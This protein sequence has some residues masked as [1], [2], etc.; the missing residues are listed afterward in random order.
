M[1]AKGNLIQAALVLQTIAFLVC[2]LSP[3]AW[4][5]GTAYLTGYVF[6]PTGATVPNATVV[7]KNEVTSALFNLRTTEAGLYRSPALTPGSYELTVTAS[8]FQTLVSRGVKVETGQPRGLN[9]TLQVGEMSQQV[10]VTASAPLLKTEDPGLGQSVQ[11]EAVKSLP[12]FN[13]SAGTLMQLSPGVRYTGEDALSYGSSRYNVGGTT[14][15]EVQVDGAGVMGDRQGAIQM[16][17]NPSVESLT[18]A[19]VTSNQY[20]SEHGWQEGAVIQM[21]TKSGSNLFHG[22]VYEY[23]RNE[24]MDTY[25]GFTNTKPLD[26]QHVF[27]G[28]LGG[29][30]KKNK[31]VF[32][33]SL[34]GWRL[35]TPSGTTLTVPTADMKRG[36]FSKLTSAAGAPTLIFDPKTTRVDPGTGN[37]VRDPFPG[38][39]IPS[40]R[41]DA[42]AANALRYIPDP[43]RS[44]LVQNLSG[45]SGF[46]N[47]KFKG[48][49]RIDWTITDKDKLFG[50]WMFDKTAQTDLGFSAY[51]AIDP[52]ASPGSASAALGYRYFTQVYNFNHVHI[53]SPTTFLESRFVYKPRTIRRVQAAINPEKHYAETLGIKNYAGARL[54]PELGGDLG[55]PTFN[56][57]GYTQ[58]GPGMLQFVEKPINQYS[59]HVN[60]SYLHGKHAT[61]FGFQTERGQHGAP[62]QTLPTG[63]FNFGPIQTSRPGAANT[64]N[65][66]ASFLLGQVN[67]GQ[68]QLGPLQV[69]Q[70]WYYAA[71]IQDD[72]KVTPKLTVNLG[73][74]WDIDAPLHERENKANAFDAQQINPVS[75][76][77]GVYRFFGLDGWPTNYFDTDYTRFAPR[78]GFAWQVEPKTVIRGGYGIYNINMVL[79]T[80]GAPREGYNTIAGFTS[81][82]GGLSP[83]F[84]LQDG[85]PDYPLGGDVSRL[86]A[87]FGAVRVG[88]SPTNSPSFVS[89]H[90]NFGYTQNFNLSVMRELPWNMVLEVAGQ[91]S[92]GRNL[93]MT[94]NWNEVRPEL[95][96]ISGSSFPRRPFPQFNN[97]T[98][99]KNQSGT[100]NFYAGYVRLEKRM[101]EGLTIISNYSYGKTLG[102]LSGS[103]YFPRFSRGPTV[104]DQGNGAT[105]APYHTA[106]VSWVYNLPFGPGKSHLSSGLASK[107]LG[108]WDVS[109]ILT[110]RGGVPFD[111]TSGADS[112]NG[113]SPLGG[114][115]NLIGNPESGSR[116]VSRWFNTDAFAR[117]VAGRV[118]DFCCGVLRSP[119]VGRLN[120]SLG[121]DIPLTEQVRLRFSGEFFNFTNSLQWGIPD[122]NLSSPNFGRISGPGSGQGA[123]ASDPGTGQRIVQLGLRIEF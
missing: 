118:G 91:G 26:R 75:G 89:R 107:I 52:A 121:K 63:S 105:G 79:G 117:P 106:L 110:I 116:S 59:Y 67:S 33:T 49:T 76:T 54:P 109:G 81:P 103:I 34:E 25:N 12:Y 122:G 119:R 32:F 18:E 14:S 74:R 46:V 99:V 1:K 92:L 17:I 7:L 50:V 40:A 2:L 24:A 13:R 43:D 30:I 65:S 86:T 29:P 35:T 20:S 85:F 83:A 16:I 8:G 64:G 94:R 37:L 72:W 77:P 36:D 41:I 113:N 4:G 39:I 60:L 87:A 80:R 82:D 51:N 78:F 68:T 104:Y 10:D 47:N 71:F 112:L 123:N 57:T 22:A 101:S 58:L 45:T 62:D 11:Y 108:G 23:F 55:F 90:W 48:V 102:F 42:V 88:Q 95:W 61:K 115:V 96:G 31:V 21:Q 69:W 3:T 5:Q 56:F 53:F 6:D 9:L 66:I 28:T 120:V 73:L 93:S 98:E 84:I 38:N 27:G 15:A 19:K 44:G 97:V 100:T 70:N 114:R 111:I